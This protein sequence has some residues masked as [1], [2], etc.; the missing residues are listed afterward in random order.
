MALRALALYAA[1]DAAGWSY[2]D[3]GRHNFALDRNFELRLI[4]GDSYAQGNGRPMLRKPLASLKKAFVSQMV[5]GKHARLTA[6]VKGW[7]KKGPPAAAAREELL[8]VFR[9]IGGPKCA[10]AAMDV[11]VFD[12]AYARIF[13]PNCG[14]TADASPLET[15]DCEQLKRAE[16][17]ARMR[18]KCDGLALPNVGNPLPA[19][20]D[21]HCGPQID[22]PPV[23]PPVRPKLARDLLSSGRR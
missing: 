6:L 23:R 16:H 11:T 1:Q 7:G 8:E 10:K 22:N 17:R 13:R 3:T 4:D 2:G 14:A 12:A 21:V 18:A 5:R 9:A 20:A 15:A 19:D